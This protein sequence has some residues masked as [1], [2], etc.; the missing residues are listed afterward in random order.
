MDLYQKKWRKFTGLI[1]PFQFMPFVDFVL[2]SGSLATRNIRKESDFDVI[3][4]VRNGRI[5]TARFLCFLIFK[6]LGSW[7]K[8]PGNSADKLCFNHFVAPDGY[9]LKPPHNAYWQE[10]YSKLIPIYGDPLHIQR[11]YR[12]NQHWMKAT[13]LYGEDS[14]HEVS[15]KNIV[16]K[17]IEEILS[18]DFGNWLEEEL[19][20][21][22]IRKIEKSRDPKNEYKP[23]MIINDDE[24]EFHPDTRRI[25]ERM[26]NFK[27]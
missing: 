19:K 18:G 27:G 9:T 8:H 16:G 14:R 4:G 5:F 1:W 22:Q 24:L 6:L 2:A 21:I 13:K 23:R 25:E 26:E 17:T 3:V 12:A 15:G 7:A 20:K 11:F 10:L